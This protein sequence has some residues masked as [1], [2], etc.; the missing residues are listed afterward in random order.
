[1]LMRDEEETAAN[2]IKEASKGYIRVAVLIL[3]S[4]ESAHG[5]E[6]MKEIKDRTKGLWMPTPGGVYPIL[7]DLEKAGYIEGKWS[8][9][10]N[11]RI[12][13]Y[14]IT[15]AGRLVFRRAIEKQNELANSMNALF[16]EFAK[17][18][19]NMEQTALPMSVMPTPFSRF[20]EDKERTRESEPTDL[21]KKRR[22][23]SRTIRV[24]KEELRT[25]DGELARRVSRAQRSAKRK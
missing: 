24:L 5:Y 16:R 23:L 8:V 4:R 21:V 15:E 13:V 12:K 20:L 17:E 6:I 25:T 22:Y 10:R 7:R 11:R 2:W 9:Q 3:L 19:L 1:M 18:V 14:E